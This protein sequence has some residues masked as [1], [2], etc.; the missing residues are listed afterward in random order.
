[1]LLSCRGQANSPSLS[2][3]LVEDMGDAAQMLVLPGQ[4]LM[5][6]LLYR[7]LLLVDPFLRLEVAVQIPRRVLCSP[8]L[9]PSSLPPPAGADQQRQQHRT[10]PSRHVTHQRWPH[11]H[12]SWRIPHPSSV[13]MDSRQKHASLSYA[14]AR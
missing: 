2:R 8:P 11:P 5:E 4:L 7:R 3:I 13:P 9:A 1:M 10:S 12:S 14:R 6:P